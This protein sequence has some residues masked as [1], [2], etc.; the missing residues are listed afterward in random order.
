MLLNCKI[1]SSTKGHIGDEESL[2]RRVLGRV[3]ERNDTVEHTC[4]LEYVLEIEVVI[5][6]HTHGAKDDLISFSTKCY[7]S[8]YLVVRLIRVSKERNLLTGN[9]GVVEVDAC[10]TGSDKLRRLLTA[11]GVHR[12]TANLHF[13]TFHFR[14]TIN[15][16]AI[17]VE[18]TAGELV[19]HL[20]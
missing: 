10:N 13:R 16:I 20:Q 17:S 3:N 11:N 18:E 2:Y 14:T 7:V 15:R 1:L 9:E 6:G 4:I 8:H 12:R 19:A 5:V